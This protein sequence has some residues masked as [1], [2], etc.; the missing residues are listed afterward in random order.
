MTFFLNNLDEPRIL[1]NVYDDPWPYQDKEITDLWTDGGSDHEAFL[2]E[3]CPFNSKQPGKGL[4]NSIHGFLIQPATKRYTRTL[5]PI[6]SPTKIAPCFSDILS[7]SLY[8]LGSV[9]SYY[10]SK[11]IL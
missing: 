8:Y 7:P 2:S 11:L 9:H 6:F 1:V 3:Y 4:W 5:L 10:F